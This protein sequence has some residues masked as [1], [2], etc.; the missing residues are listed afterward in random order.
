MGDRGPDRQGP[1]LIVKARQGVIELGES[2]WEIFPS[3]S[4]G[5]AVVEQILPVQFIDLLVDE[6]PQRRTQDADQRQAVMRI[7]HRAQQ[8]DGID[9]FFRRIKMALAFDDV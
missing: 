4:L 2:R 9:N 8:V 1:S 6:S 5:S 3:E 7:F